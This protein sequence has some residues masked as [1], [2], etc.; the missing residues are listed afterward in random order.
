MCFAGA[1]QSLVNR[2]YMR[3]DDVAAE[4]SIERIHR[5]PRRWN[6]NLGVHDKPL[7]GSR[8]ELAP[9]PYGRVMV[10][11]GRMQQ[12]RP[13]ARA[14]TQFLRHRITGAA[15]EAGPRHD[16]KAIAC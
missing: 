15:A 13:G 6:E 9:C 2:P 8:G 7:G 4:R 14:L 3:I 16:G 5:E 12:P 11:R 1:A 10:R